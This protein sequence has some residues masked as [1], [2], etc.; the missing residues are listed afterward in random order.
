MFRIAICDDERVF[1]ESMVEYISEYMEYRN[2]PYT[3]DAFTALF[4]LEHAQ[5]EQKYDLLFLDIMIRSDSGMEYAI[6]QDNYRGGR[7]RSRSRT[8]DEARTAVYRRTRADF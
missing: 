7:D 2:Y 4:E 5:K 6:Y 3:V 1:N 8:W